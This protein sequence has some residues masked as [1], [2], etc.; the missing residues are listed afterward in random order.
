[1]QLAVL[2]LCREDCRSNKHEKIKRKK[3]KKKN[4]G[5]GRKKGK[6]IN[7]EYFISLSAE[8]LS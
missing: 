2:C 6:R 4:C 7:L 1:V 3:K 8:L 5:K